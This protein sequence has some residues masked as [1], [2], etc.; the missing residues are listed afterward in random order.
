MRLPTRF[1]LSP[2][3]SDGLDA[4]A[5]KEDHFAEVFSVTEII[6]A[7]TGGGTVLT[8]TG[9]SSGQALPILLRSGAL[10]GQAK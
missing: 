2:L 5:F 9:L 8:T 7:A 4:K 10:L 6:F 3:P 1:S